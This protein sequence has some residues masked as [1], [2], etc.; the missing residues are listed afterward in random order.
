M[1]RAP[2]SGGVNWT[3]LKPLSNGKSRPAATRGSRRTPSRDRHS[4]RGID[5]LELQ[6]DVL[7]ARDPVRVVSPDTRRAHRGLLG[8]CQGMTV[9]LSPLR[10]TRQ[11]P[12]SASCWYRLGGSFG[13]SPVSPPSMDPGVREAVR[14]RLG[15]AIFVPSCAAGVDR[16]GDRGKHHFCCAP[17]GMADLGGLPQW[18]AA[19]SVPHRL[20]SYS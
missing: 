20:A 5:H 7:D 4:R 2:E 12:W 1:N 8:W 19:A 10:R 16:S 9:A 13:T 14:D 11:T 15:L 17:I 6:V 18:R 3:A